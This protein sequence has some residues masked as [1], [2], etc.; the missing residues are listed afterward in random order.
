MVYAHDDNAAYVNLFVQGTGK[1]QMK[2][3]VVNI[4]QKTDYP[5]SGKVKLTVTTEKP[6][7]FALNI[8]IPGWARGTA[9]RSDLYRIKDG[10]KKQFK[11]AWRVNGRAQ[12]GP[13]EKGYAVIRRNWKSGDVVELELPMQPQRVLAHDNV[14]P[15]RGR[16]A[17]MRGPVVY[18]IE[19]AD[20]EGQALNIVLPDESPLTA[21]HRPDLLGGVTVLRTSGLAANRQKDGSISTEA[22]KV[23]MIPY[24]AWCHR[25]ANQMQVWMPRTVQKAQP[26]PARDD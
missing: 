18:C 20:H 12:S 6:G 3:R 17:V 25:G 16:T 23:T 1:I 2:D 19:G 8:R 9:I 5:W 10:S 26:A 4:T 13:L 11:P 15:D 14:I 21:K 24:Y 22:I 7:V